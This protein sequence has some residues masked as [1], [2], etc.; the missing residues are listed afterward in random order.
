MGSPPKFI[1]IYFIV[2]YGLINMCA[3]M[4]QCKIL[5]R[6]SP[7]GYIYIIESRGS[8]VNADFFL[9]FKSLKKSTVFK[10]VCALM[11]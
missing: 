2:M 4:R 11:R 10:H 1:N 6:Q 7:L 9:V 8:Y 3:T 5:M